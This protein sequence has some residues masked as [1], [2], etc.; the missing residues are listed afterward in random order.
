MLY[1]TWRRLVELSLTGRT[2][3]E[4]TQMAVFARIGGYG[5]DNLTRASPGSTTFRW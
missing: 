2:G 1:D 4:Q 5:D 3:P